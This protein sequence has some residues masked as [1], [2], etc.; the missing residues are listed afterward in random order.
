[1]ISAGAS[2]SCSFSCAISISDRYFVDREPLRYRHLM[3]TSQNVGPQKQ[4]FNYSSTVSTR[5]KTLITDLVDQVYGSYIFATWL[6]RTAGAEFS[7]LRAPGWRT[8]NITLPP[9]K[10]EI[11]SSNIACCCFGT[12]QDEDVLHNQLQILTDCSAVALRNHIQ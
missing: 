2:A 12:F 3:G 9:C 1:M 6:H 8:R 7:L 11:E 5:K 10:I 4:E